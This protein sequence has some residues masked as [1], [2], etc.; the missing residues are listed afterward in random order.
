MLLETTTETTTGAAVLH[1]SGGTQIFVTDELHTRKIVL[2]V[3]PGHTIR[4]VTNQVIAIWGGSDYLLTQSQWSLLGE[5]TVGPYNLQS[6]DTLYYTEIARPE[7]F[8]WA[9]LG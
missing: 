6:L 7:S 2:N 5:T 9:E 8:W 3:D 4:H 1:L